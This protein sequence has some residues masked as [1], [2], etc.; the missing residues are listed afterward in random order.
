MPEHTEKSPV[1]PTKT[2]KKPVFYSTIALI[3]VMLVLIAVFP[4]RSTAVL[5]KLQLEIIHD[6]GW[7]YLLSVAIFIAFCLYFALSRFGEIKLS[8]DHI[9]PDYSYLSWF[10][11]LFSAGM[12]IGLLF[13][14]VAEPIMHYIDPPAGIPRAAEAAS[15]AMSL[16]FF[17]WGIH[18]WA[19]Y[20]TVGLALAYFSFRHQLPLAI[21]SALFPLFRKRIYGWIGHTVDTLAAI[22]TMTGVATSLGLGVLQINAGLNYLTGL[23]D[24][25]LTQSILIIVITL[26]ASLSVFLGLYAGIRR[27]SLINLWMALLLLTYVFIVG[28]SLSL[29]RFFVQNIGEYLSGIVHKTFNLYAYNPREWLS[30]WT[31]FYWGWWISWSPFVGMFIARISRGRTIREFVMGVLFVPVIFTSIWITVFGNTALVIEQNHPGLLSDAVHQQIEI[32]IFK[33]FE[34]LPLTAFAS[35]LAILVTT[36]FFITS[37]DSAALVVDIIVSGGVISALWYRRVFWAV[38]AGLIA[39]LLLAAGGLVALQTAAMAIALPFTLVILAICYSLLKAL[40]TE[41]LKR[42]T[43]E[44]AS[45]PGRHHGTQRPWQSRLKSLLTYPNLEKSQEFIRQVAAPALENISRELQ[46]ENV[47]VKFSRSPMNVSI[48]IKNKSIQNFFYSVGLKP[49]LR[50]NFAV[51]STD[52]NDDETAKYYR[53]EVYLIEGGQGYDVMGYSINELI[54]D[55][56]YQYNKYTE[57]LHISISH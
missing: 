15:Q 18:A 19:I 14:S 8:Q 51:N 3:T 35:F 45:S 7:F 9:E 54:N 23:P 55:V 27:L 53:A 40:Q 34:Q 4:S 11:M 32:A 37:M 44:N 12:G 5:Q 20:V 28:P 6:F 10:A 13:F 25:L 46:K 24:N 36:V 33:L 49:Y 22:A 42:N 29:P 31:L 38:L 1:I 56:L 30:S 43:G 2:L 57:F 21:R 17:H 41:K 26:I 16:A 39:I 48:E 47:T 50:P 52:I